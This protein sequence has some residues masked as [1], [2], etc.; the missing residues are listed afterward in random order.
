[1][2]TLGILGGMG[3]EATVLLMQ[4]I[5]NSVDAKDDCDHIPMIIH[6]NTQ[7][8]S[9]ILRIIE[10]KGEDPSLILKKMAFDLQNLQCDFLAM[11]CNTAHYYHSDVSRSIQIPLLNMIELSVQEL[12]ENHLTKIGILASPAVKAVG[13][14]DQSFNE[15]GLEFQFAQNDSK[16][17]DMIKKIKKGKVGPS[18]IDAFKY[19]STQ[20]LNDNCDALLI[21]CTE[22]SLLTKYLPNNVLCVDSLDSLTKKIVSLAINSDPLTVRNDL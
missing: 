20:L 4:K 19:E 2:K 1:M 8:P 7:V 22:F 17:L 6:Q 10:S 11:P 12:S 15:S 16:M 21:A 14:F 5:I 9:R 13:V 18:V 3:P